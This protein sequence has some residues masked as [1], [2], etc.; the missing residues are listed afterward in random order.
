MAKSSKKEEPNLERLKQLIALMKSNGLVELDYEDAD[1][2]VRL[3]ASEP[4]NKSD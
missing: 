3:R 2:K 4:A 1:I